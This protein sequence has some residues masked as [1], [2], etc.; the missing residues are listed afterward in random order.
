MGS[1][2][3]TNFDND[4]AQDFVAEVEEGGIDRIVSAIEVIKSIDED[5][6]LDSDLCAEA[7]AAIE[8]IATAK[9]HMAEDFPEDAE[10]WVNA[11]KA[12][13]Q[14]IRGIV[15]KCQQA[16]DR[17]KNNSELK[18]LWEETEDFENWKKVLDDLNTR[19]S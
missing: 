1:W 2:G 13:L 18:D 17:I 15:V 8:Y 11:H 12:Q 4:T 9:G 16:I 5:A 10:D 7:L 6:Y 19:I 3:F 14:I